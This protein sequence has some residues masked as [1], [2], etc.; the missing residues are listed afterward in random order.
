M[1]LKSLNSIGNQIAG[2][3]L[4]GLAAGSAH[5]ETYPSSPVSIIVPFSTGGDADQ[6]ARSL[7]AAVQG[8]L[9]Q[10]VIVQ[11]RPG[12]NGATGSQ[13]VKD[14]KP[15]GYT[16]LLARIGSQAL[17]P[18]LKPP[19]LN[20]RWNDFTFL[21]L[22]EINPVV[23]V[24]HPESPYK[25]FTDL[26]KDIKAGP[27]KLNYSSTGPATVLNLAPQL[28]LLNLNLKRND[29]LNVPYK[30]GGEAMLAVMS[31]EVDFTC[32]NVSSMAGLISAGKLRPLVTTTPERLKQFPDIPT[33][34]ELGF[35]QME[36]A[37]GWGALVGPPKLPADV[38]KKMDKVLE[39]VV[40]D[41]RW[42]ATNVGYGNTPKVLSPEATEKY[43]SE[44]FS[45]YQTLIQKT[46]L[47]IK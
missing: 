8:L 4:V 19:G 44:N 33:A 18:A 39:G 23:C 13:A 47:E 31:R 15:D 1:N 12:V 30:G 5:A 6:S 10:P 25:T 16:L 26:A 34:R 43:V 38:V 36:A 45:A 22:L 40:A 32:N 2:C 20:Y 42:V 35:P 29:A 3:C 17:L 27:G 11:S 9:G 46:G 41:Q 21:G 28:L 14:A 24:V 37:L 7:V